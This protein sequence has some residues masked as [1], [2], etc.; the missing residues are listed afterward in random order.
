LIVANLVPSNSSDLIAMATAV[1]ARAVNA[2]PCIKPY[3]AMFDFERH[4]QNGAT[5][6]G[7]HNPQLEQGFERCRRN[8]AF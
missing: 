3:L 2:P 6:F 7:S 8:P 4:L 1:S 5:L